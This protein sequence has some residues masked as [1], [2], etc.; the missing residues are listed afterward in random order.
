M[1]L[2]G[3]Y[4]PVIP[5]SVDTSLLFFHKAC[6][7][8]HHSDESFNISRPT[9]RASVGFYVVPTFGRNVFAFLDYS[10]GYLRF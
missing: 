5:S 1:G 2:S 6:W 4:I 9:S 3:E 8:Y 10:V 7:T